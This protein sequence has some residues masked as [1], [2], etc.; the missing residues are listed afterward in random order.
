MSEYNEDQ[1]QAQSKDYF[2]LFGYFKWED[3]QV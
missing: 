3:K 2:E 1:S